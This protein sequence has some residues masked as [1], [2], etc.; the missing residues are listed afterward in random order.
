MDKSRKYKS[1]FSTTAIFAISTVLSKI[2]LSLLLPLYTRMLTTE[3]YGTAELLTTISQLVMPMCSLAI[4]DSVFRFS[5]EENCKPSNVLC[6]AV[7]VASAASGILLVASIGLNWYRAL[8]EWTHYFWLISVLTMFR[9]IF[10]LYA[11]AT[12]RTTTY[13]V[14]NVLYNGLLAVANVV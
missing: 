12:H 1:L 3:Q 7:K 4:Q 14:D 2:V 6:N 10:S 11:N 5:M 9:A 13:A 8:S